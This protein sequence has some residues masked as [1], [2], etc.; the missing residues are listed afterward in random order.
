MSVHSGEICWGEDARKGSAS[1]MADDLSQTANSNLLKRKTVLKLN[2][3]NRP[4]SRLTP[5]SYLKLFSNS[6]RHQL[7]LDI[8]AC[9]VVMKMDGNSVGRVHRGSQNQYVLQGTWSITMGSE[10]GVLA[11][12][13]DHGHFR[14]ILTTAGHSTKTCPNYPSHQRCGVAH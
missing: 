12:K 4:L 3:I 13:V 1:I 5:D 8:Q 7:K 2:Q 11:A 9:P 14:Y 10:H 6:V